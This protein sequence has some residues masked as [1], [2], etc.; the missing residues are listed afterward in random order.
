MHLNTAGKE[1]KKH[2]S[3]LEVEVLLQEYRMTYNNY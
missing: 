1:K 3:S 2:F